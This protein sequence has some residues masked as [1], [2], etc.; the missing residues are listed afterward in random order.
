MGLRIRVRTSRLKVGMALRPVT[1]GHRAGWTRGRQ[2]REGLRATLHVRA[3]GCPGSHRR[4]SESVPG[5]GQG[6]SPCAP[7]GSS[8][9]CAPA[10]GTGLSGV[11]GTVGTCG[12]GLL[13]REGGEGRGGAQ[14]GGRVCMHGHC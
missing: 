4:H 9:P 13:R 7:H 6:G 11:G 5:C 2:T 8:S 12:P 1:R 3:L 14:L 10:A